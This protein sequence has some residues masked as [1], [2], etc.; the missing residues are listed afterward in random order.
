LHA[1]HAGVPLL[2]DATYGGP[3]RLV[4]RG[5]AVRSLERVALHAAWVELELGGERLRVVAGEPADLRAL[6][7]ELSGAPEAWADALETAL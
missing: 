4:V 2:G 7:G 3:A 1:A 5:G 6:W